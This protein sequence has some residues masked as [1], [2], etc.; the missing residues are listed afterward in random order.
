MFF[1]QKLDVILRIELLTVK[2]FITTNLKEINQSY[3]ISINQIKSLILFMFYLYCMFDNSILNFYIKIHP[4]YYLSIDSNNINN[5]LVIKNE[6][7]LTLRG[8]AQSSK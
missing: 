3:S 1:K 6:S 7:F 2:D 8:R 4:P 5:L